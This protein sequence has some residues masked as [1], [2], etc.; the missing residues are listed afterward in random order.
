M[1]KNNMIERISSK[2]ILEKI[3]EY[4]RDENIK[5]KIFRYSKSLQKKLNITFD[6]FGKYLLKI[7]FKISDYF[8]NPN[9]NY[10]NKNS[11]KNKLDKFLSENNINN[12]YFN[13]YLNSY[14]KKTNN[15]EEK[16]IDIYSPFFELLFENNN[17]FDKLF[18][19]IPL[20]YFNSQNLKNDYM[21]IFRRLKSSNIKSLS[22]VF[23]FEKIK[24][25]EL[26]TEF[27]LDFKIKKMKIECTKMEYSIN[28]SEFFQILS[29]FNIK[30]NLTYLEINGI[31]LSNDEQK[32]KINQIGCINNLKSMT[33][34][35]LSRLS[36]DDDSIIEITNLKILNIS[37][38][39]DIV[40]G[41]KAFKNLKELYLYQSIIKVSNSIKL[42]NVEILQLHGEYMWEKIIDFSSLSKI[43]RLEIDAK[44]FFSI[45][46]CSTL[47]NIQ[48]LKLCYYIDDPLIFE[49]EKIEEILYSL[50]ELT[51]SMPPCQMTN[52]LKIEDLHI[53]F[54]KILTLNLYSNDYYFDNKL[55]NGAIIKFINSLD[56]QIKE[57]NI[58]GDFGDI[59]IKINCNFKKLEKIYI[60]TCDCKKLLFPIFCQSCDIFESLT[61]FTFK[62][63]YLNF[64]TLV[65]IYNNI[66]KMPNLKNFTLSCNNNCFHEYLY[67]KFIGELSKLKLNNIYIDIRK[68]VDI[69]D[70]D[71]E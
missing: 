38:C 56:S 5:L 17:N 71:D 64:E 48:K 10:V 68:N 7:G 11:L 3:C 35:K 28:F 30:T 24:D 63:N 57:I 55:K 66:E 32:S 50:T 21:N 9:I 27:N 26:F 4:I 58:E 40:L 51:I 25:V 16:M 52:N 20:N 36:L 29:S 13:A 43:K 46:K 54:Q 8:C 2:Y 34:L 19:I 53:K 14:F 47:K 22:L 67:E 1:N 18:I 45:Q 62:Y 23:I 33:T 39:K 49:N 12:N 6:Y 59:N 41:E 65:N 70:S 15:Y 44:N 37:Y 69:R 42:P 61:D 31:I 60:N